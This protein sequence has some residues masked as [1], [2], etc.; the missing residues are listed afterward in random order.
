[1]AFGVRTQMET[2]ARVACETDLDEHLSRKTNPDSGP[3]SRT[4][5]TNPH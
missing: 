1:M 4:R 2:G 5:G 3:T